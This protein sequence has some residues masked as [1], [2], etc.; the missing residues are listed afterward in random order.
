M[1][2]RVSADLG[3]ER[4]GAALVPRSPCLP[5][6]VPLH[7]ELT[8]CVLDGGPFLSPAEHLRESTAFEKANLF[9]WPQQCF[10]VVS[11]GAVVCLRRSGACAVGFIG[12]S[13][14]V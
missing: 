3:R 10:S 8:A 2:L 6:K 9:I 12:S 11:L 13:E 7:G 14:C 1:G 5:Q 4:W